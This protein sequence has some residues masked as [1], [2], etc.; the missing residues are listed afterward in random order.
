ME[1]YAI[2]SFSEVIPDALSLA[3]ELK[4]AVYDAAFLALAKTLG[5]RLLTLDVKLAKTIEGTKY[6]DFVE[7]PK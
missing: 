2:H 4:I 6:E 1:L 3:L 5:V 7:Y